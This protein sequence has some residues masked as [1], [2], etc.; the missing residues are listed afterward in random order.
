MTFTSVLDEAGFNGDR[1]SGMS[2]DERDMVYRE[3]LIGRG[4]LAQR[5]DLSS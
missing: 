3:H 2:A 1:L 5:T 4:L